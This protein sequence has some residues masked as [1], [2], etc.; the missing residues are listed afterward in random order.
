MDFQAEAVPG[1]VAVNGQTVFVDCLA[2]GGIDTFHLDSGLYLFYHCSLSLFDNI[3]NFSIKGSRSSDYK[4][5]G[6][7]AAVTF[8]FGAEV[9]QDGIFLFELS[10]AR[11]MMRPGAIRAESDYR[12]ETVARPELADL[13]IEHA[14]QLAFGYAGFDVRQGLRERFC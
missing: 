6:N 2:G 1:A 9:N 4:A 12:L 11:L 10:F 7:I 3:V 5:S 13:K 14:G 8:I